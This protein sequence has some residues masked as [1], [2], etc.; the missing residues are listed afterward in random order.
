MNAYRAAELIGYRRR[1]NRVG[2]GPGHRLSRMERT[3]MPGFT[4]LAA[5]A[6]QRILAVACADGRGGDEIR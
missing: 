5:S 2:G 6:C 4:G 3:V 1:C